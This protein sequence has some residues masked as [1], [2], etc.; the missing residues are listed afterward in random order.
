MPISCFRRFHRR[1]LAGAAVSCLLLAGCATVRRAREAQDATHVPPG[2]RTVTAAEAGL[3]SNTVL[4]L[5]QALGI[6]RQ[7]NPTLIRAR[8]A[9]ASSGEQLRQTK[10]A[11]YPNVAASANARRA[12]SNSAQAPESHNTDPSYSA[13][14]SADQ[15]LY[16]FGKT[17]AAL[18]QAAAGYAATE[19]RLRSTDHTIAFNVRTA[20]YDL[21]RA[22]ELLTVAEENERQYKVRLEEVRALAEVGRRIR[23]DITKA[24]VDLGNAQVQLITARNGVRTAR[25]TL[26]H[27]LGLAEEPAFRMADPPAVEAP[28]R[29]AGLMDT[30]RAQHPDLAALRADVLAASAA[31]DQAVANLYPSLKVNADYGWSGKALPLIWNWAA[32]LGGALDV[33]SG[34]RNTSLI[35]QSVAQLRSARA[36]YAEREQQIH[37]DLSRAWAELE[38]ARERQSVTELTERAARET[39]DL[40]S[41]RYR[42]GKASS[43]D[44]SDAQV[45]LTTARAQQVQARY[46]YLSAVAAIQFTSGKD[47][48]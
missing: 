31:V 44:L 34:W 17:P 28:A 33:F 6:A 1:R 26:N 21:L 10:A 11:F 9:L 42:I 48:P 37:E 23:Y 45:A 15:L 16:D 12:T 25:A 41:E 39:L 19:A 47:E 24:E 18:R 43:V 29:L 38:S 22:Q 27:R 35:E 4:S 30:A 13:G 20:F 32:A 3:S 8:Q 2:E 40:V 7:W 14:L 5:D 46:D 36:A